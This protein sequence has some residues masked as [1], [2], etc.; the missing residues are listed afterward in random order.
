M[1]EKVN[2]PLIFQ[3]ERLRTLAEYLLT[4]K[5]NGSFKVLEDDNYIFSEEDST[6]VNLFPVFECVVTAL[7]KAFPEDWKATAHGVAH[8]RCDERMCL[9]SNIILYFGL[10]GDQFMHL[11]TPYAQEPEVYGGTYLVRYATPGDIAH[12]ISELICFYELA[13]ELHPDIPIFIS[14][15]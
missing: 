11:F 13:M 8:R 5:R 2:K 10:D 15:N 12:N 3:P 1:I 7:P 4:R 14:K 9:L 6:V